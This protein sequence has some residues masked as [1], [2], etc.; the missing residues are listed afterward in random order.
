MKENNNDDLFTQMFGLPSESPIEKKV[1]E[2]VENKIVENNQELNISNEN[3]PIIELSSNKIE[4]ESQKEKPVI[5]PTGEQQV[6][7]NKPVINSTITDSQNNNNFKTNQ[8]PLVKDSNDNLS[9]IILV[10]LILGTF[11]VIGGFEVYKRFIVPQ[12]IE[13][14]TQ[15]N[16]NKEE[17][18]P[19]I[20][21][22]SDEEEKEI[23]FDET[24]AFEKGVTTNP[25]ELNQT[26]SYTPIE[27][28]GVIKCENINVIINPNFTE[29]NEYY[30][31]YK[32]Y[33]L[34]KV[35]SKQTYVY[36]TARNYNT[37]LQY[38]EALNKTFENKE[39]LKMFIAANPNTKT[40]DI[41]SLINLA[42][43][44]YLYNEKYDDNHNLVIKLRYNYDENIKTTLTKAFDNN[45]VG[46]LTCS[47]LET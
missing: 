40:I 4:E 31:Y 1:N 17:N 44:T 3:Q 33:Q 21:E 34:K 32:N 6:I 41:K 25:S 23:I 46:N 7:L 39:V 13:S 8:E 5:N 42:Y 12:L 9:I 28:T 30:Y 47:T 37:D 19:P 14:S 16:E 35:I 2:K 38:F 18:I 36:D 22:P 10:I 26:I 27:P 11:L 20:E 43:N 29:K 24:L 15:K 45:E